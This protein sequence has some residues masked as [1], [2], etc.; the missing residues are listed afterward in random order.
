MQFSITALTAIAFATLSVAAPTAVTSFDEASV[1]TDAA[2]G[3]LI[4]IPQEAV[5]GA[6][7]IANDLVPV[8][9]ENEGQIYL[10]V[11]N[12]TLAD[13]LEAS[14]KAS[15]EKRDAEAWHWLSKSTFQPIFK[16]DAEA[17]HWLSKSTFQPIF[18]RNAEAWH[19]LS[20]STFQPIF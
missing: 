18:K 14:G 12:G 2:E 8:I 20:K 13:E 19:W 7:P 9:I 1:A 15:N 10:L 6:S 3:D 17:W 5:L 11:V 4:R 16:R